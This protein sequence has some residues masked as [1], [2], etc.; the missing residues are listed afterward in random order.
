MPLKIVITGDNH[1]NY[2]SQRFGSKI[3]ERRAQ[4]GRA[5]RETIDF[6]IKKKVDFYLNVG[7]LFD[8]ISPRNPP[9]ARV[10]EAFA[11]LKDAGIRAFVIAGT[12][13]SPATRIEGA[14]PHLLLQ[15]AGFLE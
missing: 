5:W 2:Y 10:I 8:Q 13:D 9:R 4:I 6:A 15:E 11:D 1:L 7:D 3:A 14:S 12:H